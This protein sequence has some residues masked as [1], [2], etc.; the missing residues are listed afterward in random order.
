MVNYCFKCFCKLCTYFQTNTP[1]AIGDSLMLWEI[2]PPIVVRHAHNNDDDDDD[3]VDIDVDIDV[4]DMIM[5][6]S[7][8]IDNSANY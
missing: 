1:K 3:D 6:N 8:F 2:R 4:D 5:I 7:N